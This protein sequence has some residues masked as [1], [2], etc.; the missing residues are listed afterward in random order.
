MLTAMTEEDWAVV[1]RVF[2]AIENAQLPF[3]DA[4]QFFDVAMFL[5]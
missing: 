4:K 3:Q 1:L 2:A 5:T